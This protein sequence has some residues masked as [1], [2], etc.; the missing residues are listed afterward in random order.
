[1]MD[2]PKRAPVPL[3]LALASGAVLFLLLEFR[4]F[5]WGYGQ[6]RALLVLALLA[7]VLL[8]PWFC[9]RLPAS[10]KPAP[11]V[12]R[13]PDRATVAAGLIALALFA[14]EVSVGIDSIVFTAST[15][16]IRM[17]QGQNTYR[18]A[19]LFLRGENPYGRGVILDVDAFW[20]RLPL[21]QQAGIGPQ[22]GD[23]ELSTVLQRYWDTL[24]PEPLRQ[25][26]PLP[27]P[28][29]PALAH[30]E[31]AVLGYKYGPVLFLLAAPLARPLGPASIPL[32]N[33]VGFLAWLATLWAILCSSTL[34][35]WTW[36]IV[37]A[38][39]LATYEIPLNL[40]YL[41]ASDIWPL[42]FSSLAV[43]A[44]LHNRPVLLGI[45]LG[46]ALG[47]KL[48]PAALFLPLVLLTPRAVRAFANA[49]LVTLALYAAFFAWDPS[50]F[51]L[52]IVRWPT[53]MEPDSTS[54]IFHAPPWMVPI[55]R[56]ILAL[57]IALLFWRLLSGRE[58][59]L[60]RTLAAVHLLLLLG[61][62]AFHN[63]YVTWFA[64]WVFFSIAEV[65]AS[66][67][68]G[69]VGDSSV[70]SGKSGK[71]ALETEETEPTM[72]H[73]CAKDGRD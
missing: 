33:L 64:P 17:D 19:L 61:G 54:W 35:R 45:A 48:L 41:T 63:N 69:C 3:V 29:A 65:L 21:R 5:D 53:L 46:L 31:A 4:F 43:L 68:D 18:A 37:L 52:H 59:Y 8:L 23:G 38:S 24:D 27:G 42:L 28:D 40:L 50:S 36:S 62:G 12:A 9:R 73:N 7:G 30:R 2:M 57:G 51:L 13:S 44:L 39:V 72:G 71:L 66:P 14:I 11:V 56:S 10:D 58:E 25:I 55:A 6:E 32:L 15:G 60:F 47:S 1:M 70:K 16:T 67:K 22:V 34:P 26:L 20:T 49:A